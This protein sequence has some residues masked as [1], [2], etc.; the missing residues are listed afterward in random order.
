M[1][2]TMRT[3]EEL[4]REIEKAT[5]FVYGQMSKVGLSARKTYRHRHRHTHISQRNQINRPKL[6][7]QNVNYSPHS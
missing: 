4:E 6:S 7:L 1:Y 2:Y 5:G 3:K